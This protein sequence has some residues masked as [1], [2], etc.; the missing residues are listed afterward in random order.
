VSDERVIAARCCKCRGEFTEAEIESASACPKC[1]TKGIP[2]DPA[3][4]VDVRINWH[5][6]RILCIWAEHWAR[7]I[8]ADKP[9]DDPSIKTV[10]GIVGA[11]QE[12]FPSR[13]PLTLSGE[14]QEIAKRYEIETNV[15]LDAPMPPEVN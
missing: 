11:I 2:C 7:K 14:F 12:Q 10:Y 13:G 8:D 15:P 6:L 1:G 9:S 4:D 5:E 3:N